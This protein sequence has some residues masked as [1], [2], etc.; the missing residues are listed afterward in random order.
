[1]DCNVKNILVYPSFK[2]KWNCEDVVSKTSDICCEHL[3]NL[4]MQKLESTD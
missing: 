1:M 4:S 2:D 3:G